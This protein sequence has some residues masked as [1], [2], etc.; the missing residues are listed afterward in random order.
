LNEISEMPEAVLAYRRIALPDKSRCKC[1][2]DFANDIF[3]VIKNLKGEFTVLAFDISKFFDSLNH[4]FLKQKWS[5]LLGRK[6][7]PDDHYNIYKSLI[8]FSYLE[9]E[10][11]LKEFGFG[12]SNQLIQ[13]DVPS[14]LKNGEEFRVRIKQK[15]Y[16]RSNPFR[17]IEID[18]K[19]MEIKTKV[20]IPQGTPISAFLANLY[21]FD[22]DKEVINFLKPSNGIYRRYSDDI[23]VICPSEY[24]IA[25]EDFVMKTIDKVFKLKIQKTKTQKT[26]F[27][28]G[29]LV[30]GQKPLQYLGFEFDGRF[31]KIRSS[32]ISKYYRNLKRLIKFKA[33]RAKKMKVKIPERAFIYRKQI[34]K[35][36]SHL[37]KVTGSNRKRNYLS[38]VDLASNVMGNT[39]K[40]QL[41]KSWNI[42]DTEIKRWNIKNNL[43]NAGEYEYYIPTTQISVEEFRYIFPD[44]K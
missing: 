5:D 3:E 39:V 30:K 25:T 17:R 37:G 23:L 24:E 21:M 6:D 19:G 2:I 20:G 16:I 18:D 9:M 28:N 43:L 31:K 36:Y 10:D 14:F 35:G 26:K 8:N 1:N 15:G 40:R 44:Q 27:V 33:S 42:I 38:Y 11:V 12:H 41:S 4:K 29:K 13:K 7:L 22:Y 34:Y 32:S